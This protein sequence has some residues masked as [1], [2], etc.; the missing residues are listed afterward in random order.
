MHTRIG[1]RTQWHGHDMGD[2][3]SRH[4]LQGKGQRG[5]GAIELELDRNGALP[6]LNQGM[7]LKQQPY[8]ST[9]S[10]TSIMIS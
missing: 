5:G 3:K 2:S 6:P 10:G 7:E 1:R 4:A 8:G 9:D